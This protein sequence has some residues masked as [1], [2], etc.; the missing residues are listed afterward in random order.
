MT[1]NLTDLLN[2]PTNAGK[3][4]I[5]VNMQS[6]ARQNVLS[7]NEITTLAKTKL[8]YQPGSLSTFKHGIIFGSVASV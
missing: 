8:I 1:I 6:I 7:Q 4:K 2:E 3:S 5:A